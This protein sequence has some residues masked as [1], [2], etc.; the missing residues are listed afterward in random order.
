MVSKTDLFLIVSAFQ[1]DNTP[2]TPR[3]TVI[4]RKIPPSSYKVLLAV[5]EV[6][7]TL[8]LYDLVVRCPFSAS[9]FLLDDC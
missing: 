4:E 3:S 6:S 2:S 9:G 1:G 7:N 8:T 5:G